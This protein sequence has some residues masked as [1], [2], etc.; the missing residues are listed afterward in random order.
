MAERKRNPSRGPIPGRG[1]RRSGKHDTLLL[2]GGRVIDPASDLDEVCDVLLSRGRIQSVGGSAQA[3][4]GA[5]VLEVSGKLVVPGLIDMHVH[6]RE[7]GREDEETIESGGR[8]A[9]RGGFTTV[10]CMAN[11][12]PPIDTSGMVRYVLEA[13]ERS[14][15]VRV[16]PVAAATVG[17]KGEAPTEIFDLRAAGAA[18]LSDDGNFIKNSE[19]ARRVMEYARMAGLTLISHCEDSYLAEGGV[20]H[21]GYR[22]TVLGL[23]GIPAASETAAVAR[24]LALA[25][26]TQVRLHVAHVSTGGAVK[27]IREAKSRGLRVTAETA[28]HYLLLTDEV[29]ADY[30][31]SAKVNPPIRSKEDRD[32]ILEGLKDGTID[33]VASDHAPH[34]EEEKDVEFDVAAFGLVGLETTVGLLMAFLV[35]SGLVPLSRVIAALTVAPSTALGIDA[36]RIAPGQLADVTV[37]DPDL[38]WE[39]DPLSFASKS[40]NTPFRGTKLVGRAVTTIVGGK[41]VYQA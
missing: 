40:R 12:Q 10:A 32:A 27:L 17:L 1:P 16:L 19:V 28:P 14:S 23:K 9:A 4:P 15:P 35:K 39:V 34:C 2:R 5:E 18:A 8:A 30:D 26:L 37:I 41:I 38:A 25:E 11:T 3:G 29:V 6:L 33:V 13:A 21:E 24:E 31:T 36:G 7:P 22:S 20:M